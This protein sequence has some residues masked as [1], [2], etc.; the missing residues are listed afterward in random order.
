M[1]KY[2]YFSFFCDEEKDVDL[3]EYLL[4]MNRERSEF[5][6]KSLRANLYHKLNYEEAKKTF[7]II[8]EE[9]NK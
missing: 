4:N 1:K 2:K 6:K 3:I 8:L 7:D 9:K 5:I